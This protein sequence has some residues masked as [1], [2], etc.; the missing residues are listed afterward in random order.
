MRLSAGALLALLIGCYE[1]P[2]RLVLPDAPP[3]PA[4]E[5]CEALVQHVLA[6]HPLL[7]EARAGGALTVAEADA[8]TAWRDPEVRVRDDLREPGARWRVG[9]RMP[10]AR[11]GV[12]GA[13]S[14]ARR[15]AR[16]LSAAEIRVAEVE[17]AAEV[18]QSHL[19]LR[20]ARAAMANATRRLA[21]AEAA[22]EVGAERVAV[23]TSTRIELAAARLD[24]DEARAR[25]AAAEGDLAMARAAVARW[26]GGE[27][28]ETPCAE[29][30]AAPDEHPGV[31]AARA[32]WEGAH[33]EAAVA[34]REGWPWLDHVELTWDAEPDPD[35]DRLLLSLAVVLPF[36][37]GLGEADVGRAEEGAKRA[38]VAA[39][40][41]SA[42]DAVRLAEAGVA[43]AEAAAAA[44]VASTAE[45]EALL[46]RAADAPVDP[47]AVLKLQQAI[48]DARQRAA[49][50]EL[51]REAAAIEL[52]RARGVP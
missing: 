28:G 21:L 36:F 24:V 50:A 43:A 6:T 14:A 52:R 31:A 13:L 11:P 12:P 15:A 23:G 8:L 48:E 9:L 39:A 3:A 26:A 19:A 34:R 45:A 25:L 33:A 7:A 32:A 41:R 29:A 40:E 38:A 20:A 46:G 22:A 44:S 10:L 35:D 49:E 51:A 16:R 42:A 17:L 2:T 1:A 30:G 5:G 27:V 4:M 47:R 18:R 37:E